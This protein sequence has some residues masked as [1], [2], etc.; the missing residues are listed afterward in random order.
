[1][2]LRES[3][4]R[5]ANERG[6]A[7]WREIASAAT[8]KVDG[9]ERVGSEQM[10]RGVSP[11][12]ARQTVKNMVF[13]GELVEVG[14]EKRAGSNHWHAIYAPPEPQLEAP[15]ADSAMRSLND[16]LSSWARRGG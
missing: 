10:Q 2:A 9:F 15:A 12:V 14:R 13:A 8:L 7:S 6:G 5:L 11:K 3:A 4:I 16:M 1:V